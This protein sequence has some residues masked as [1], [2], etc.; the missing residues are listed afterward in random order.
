MLGTSPL[1]LPEWVT[2]NGSN[3]LARRVGW[4]IA[5]SK[6]QGLVIRGQPT[7]TICYCYLQF[8]IADQS[9]S[10]SDYSFSQSREGWDQSSLGFCRCFGRIQA[11]C[12]FEPVG[13]VANL[14][15]ERA[16]SDIDR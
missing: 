12:G 5:D 14:F 1:N 3:V 9:T 8:W 11:S 15:S 16:I 7:T 2:L 10:P 4:Q 13:D 6:R